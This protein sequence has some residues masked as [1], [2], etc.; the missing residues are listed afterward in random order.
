MDIPVECHEG[1][2]PQS[3]DN[4]WGHPVDNLWRAVDN[5]GTIRPLWTTGLVIHRQSTARPQ[6]HTAPEQWE[7]GL[8]PVSTGPMNKMGFISNRENKT[9]SPGL[10]LW[11]DPAN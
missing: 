3:G 8:S 7:E 9:K 4:P 2:S 11:T 6:G 10:D 1:L 5:L